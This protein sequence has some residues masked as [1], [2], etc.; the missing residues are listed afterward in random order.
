MTE[1][2]DPASFPRRLSREICRRATA[3][4]VAGSFGLWIIVLSLI[5]GKPFGLARLQEITGGPSI[6][7]MTF[8]TGPDS[9][10]AVLD[11]LGDAGRAF[12]LTH[13]VPLD[14]VFPFT[15]GLFLA[16]G[17]SWGLVRL[18]PE[19]SPWLLLNLAPVIAA[20]ADY[21]E[22]AGV[23]ALLLTYPA[24]LDPAA[25]FVSIMYIIKSGFSAVSFLT[26][27]A[28]LAGVA[29]M[30]LLHRLGRSPA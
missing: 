26:L 19:G 9:V 4:A 29:V 17:I 22:N 14:L 3:G 2:C 20:A 7:D 21:C 6:L 10:Y 5:N 8:T 13:I 1:S 27:I 30:S 25:W 18:L 15:Y 23:I 24:R 28:A 11:A 16:L 12:D